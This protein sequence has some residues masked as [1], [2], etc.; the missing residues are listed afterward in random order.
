MKD[1][2]EDY[3]RVLRRL[4]RPL[5]KLAEDPYT[6]LTRK[7][8]TSLLIVASLAIL[9]A[10]GWA[11]MPSGATGAAGAEAKAA[12]VGKGDAANANEP[13][14]EG[15]PFVLKV[16]TR[17]AMVL[18]D[19][20]T[21]YLLV[22]FLLGARSD[23]ALSRCG[24]LSPFAPV[25]ELARAAN[26]LQ[27][28]FDEEMRAIHAISDEMG[29]SSL[30]CRRE[31]QSLV[32]RQSEI[33]EKLRCEQDPTLH[34]MLQHDLDTVR[35]AA[36]EA[37]QKDSVS[38]RASVDRLL[39]LQESGFVVAGDL[40]S[41]ERDQETARRML[42]EYWNLARYRFNLEVLLP[43]AYAIFAEFTGVCAAVWA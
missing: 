24:L 15:W 6:E 1:K 34:A 18:A 40:A 32:A 12:E 17:T 30:E 14:Y 27:R 21:G 8:Q 39:A 19:I 41:A 7:R 5:S 20:A 36:V 22:M 3:Y 26:E 9:L 2:G 16:N 29:R 28:T 11:A 43:S 33:M 38:G 4:R 23:Q 35:N 13:K 37:V 42:E 10:F 25:K 31:L